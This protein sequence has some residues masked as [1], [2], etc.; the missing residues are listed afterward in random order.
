MPP[1]IK[2]ITSK[3]SF[4]PL[5]TL[6][7]PDEWDFRRVSSLEL[8]SAIAW[9]YARN[10]RLVHRIVTC[11]EMRVEG[12]TIGEWILERHSGDPST[13]ERPTPAA[14]EVQIFRTQPKAARD[15]LDFMWEFRLEKL[16]PAPWLQT[17]YEPFYPDNDVEI[18]IAPLQEFMEGL[19]NPL[20]LDH[21]VS[22]EPEYREEDRLTPTFEEC[23]SSGRYY[24]LEIDFNHWRTDEL[25][26]AFSSWVKEEA[27][28]KG[29]P[30]RG[31]ASSPPFE[32]LKWLTALR[33][34]KTTGWSY[35]KLQAALDRYSKSHPVNN[36]SDVLPNYLSDGAWSNAIRKAKE[37]ISELDACCAPS[38]PAG[39]G[40]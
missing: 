30:R 10:S 31:K 15:I 36:E 19:E 23:V 38:R 33:L 8:D 12:R 11:L 5:E 20:Y 21:V 40:P 32:K 29:P 34:R 17:G 18:G 39:K 2:S 14:V 22:K 16:F 28:K 1:R 26:Q 13:P 6:L 35:E 27:D 37:A 9:E 4:P 24:V 7:S 25:I 3:E